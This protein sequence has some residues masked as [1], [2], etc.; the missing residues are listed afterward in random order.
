M[1]P[2]TCCNWQSLVGNQKNNCQSYLEEVALMHQ[3]GL[4]F[5]GK[6]LKKEARR[7]L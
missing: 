1:T 6:G 4:S 3:I 2:N 5:L 7:N